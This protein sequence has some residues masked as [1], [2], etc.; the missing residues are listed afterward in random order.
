MS[1]HILDRSRRLKAQSP[2]APFAAVRRRTA[3]E[4]SDRISHTIARRMK[5]PTNDALR[6]RAFLRIDRGYEV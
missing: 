5:G 6:A 1:K 3:P 2:L 4:G